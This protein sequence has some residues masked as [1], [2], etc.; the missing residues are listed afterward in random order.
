MDPQ[1][2]SVPEV[3]AYRMPREVLFDLQRTE[4]VLTVVEQAAP[5]DER[6]AHLR[7]LRSAIAELQQIIS[8]TSTS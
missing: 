2:Q 6:A 5:D 4:R 1:R 7:T 3:G 8:P